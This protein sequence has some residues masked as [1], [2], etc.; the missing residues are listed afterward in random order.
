MLC[1]RIN[2]EL[3]T[4]ES[5]AWL[6]ICYKIYIH[7]RC[8][9]DWEHAAFSIMEEC[10]LRVKRSFLPRFFRRQVYKSSYKIKC[11]PNIFAKVGWF[12]G[13]L[14]WLKSTRSKFRIIWLLKILFTGT[15]LSPGMR[16]SKSARKIP[17]LIS[18]FE[19]NLSTVNSIKHQMS[20]EIRPET[21]SQYNFKLQS[22]YKKQRQY[23]LIE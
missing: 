17:V 8:T 12:G 21:H 19:M 6:M 15:F 10:F 9:A 1:Y 23:I 5:S 7:R 13:P 2:V 22:F 4:F 11:L 14:L 16:M 3:Y 18:R 20:E